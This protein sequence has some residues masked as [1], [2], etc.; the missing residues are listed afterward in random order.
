MKPHLLSVLLLVGCESGKIALGGG[1]AVDARL[2]ADLYT[3]ECDDGFG[4]YAGVYS[5][6]VSLEYAPD[7]LAPR[8]LPASG[9]SASLDLFPQ[10][11]GAGAHELDGASAPTWTNGTVAG[12]DISGV[13]AETA[14]GFYF[15]DVFANQRTCKI[16]ADVQGEGTT[17]DE[18]GVFSGVSTPAPE[19]L[20]AVHV[21]GLDA[22]VGIAFGDETRVN[23]NAGSWDES[24]VQVRREQGGNLME[25]VTCLTTGSESFTIDDAVWSLMSEFLDVDITNLYVGFQNTDVVEAEDGQKIEV[26]TRANHVAI[27]QE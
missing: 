21:A 24:Y 27:V 13:L 3:W 7:N 17:I 25:S 22:T 20:E 8:G 16:I 14:T 23:W 11:A 26:L 9:C 6:L 15:D 5:Y 19:E 18:A 4:T 12:V 2:I 1:D 10:D